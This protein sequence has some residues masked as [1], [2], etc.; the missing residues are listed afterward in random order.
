LKTNPIN[1]YLEPLLEQGFQALIKR[2]FLRILSGGA[3]V[4]AYLCSH[5]RIDTI[6]LTG[7]DKT[8]DTIVFGSGETAKQRKTERQPQLTKPMTA[9]LGGVNPVI[10]VPGAWSA[11]DIQRAA[12]MLATW[13]YSNAGFGCLAPRLLILHRQWLQRQALLDT[14]GQI[15]AETPL[16]P[17]YYPGAQARHAAFVAAH[18]EAQLFGAAESRQSAQED[19]LSWTLI[20]GVNPAHVHDICFTTEAFCALLSETALDARDTSDFLDR[21]TDFANTTVWGTLAATLL[22]PDRVQADRQV[23]AALE[24]TV[25]RLRYGTICIN[26]YTGFVYAL[27]S[28]PWGSFPG[29]EAWDIQ[30]GIGFVNNPFMLRN[31]QK[32]IFAAPFQRIDPVTIRHRS[33]AAFGKQYARFQARPSLSE[34]LKLFWIVM[35]R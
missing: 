1:A 19:T 15:L 34:L 4:G 20:P 29:Q 10:V 22:V 8:F 12:L 23:A 7:S 24:R 13:L 5:P 35:K 32:S 16:R 11:N 17:A 6:H 21:A 26:Q 33:V 3:D 27:M 2:G 18:P 9:E 28:T 31:P 30:S 25:A 14:L